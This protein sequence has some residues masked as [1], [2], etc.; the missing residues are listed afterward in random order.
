LEGMP[1]GQFQLQSSVF[2]EA[3]QELMTKGQQFAQ[4]A[5]KNVP[6]ELIARNID[7]SLL[8]SVQSKFLEQPISSLAAALDSPGE[9]NDVILRGRH[10]V[11]R[12][13]Q[14]RSFAELLQ[15]AS[16]QGEE[17]L[18]DVFMGRQRSILE[19]LRRAARNFTGEEM[20]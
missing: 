12:V 4:E 3:V 11:P 19:N 8:E 6:N 16:T 20:L 5:A 15:S 2:S 18:Q 13:F 14:G 10:R 17:E 9:I 1:F 7:A